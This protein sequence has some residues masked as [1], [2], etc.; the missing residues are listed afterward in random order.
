MVN[1]DDDELLVA[2]VVE[3]VDRL[4]VARLFAYRAFLR[5]NGT[6]PST[7]NTKKHFKISKVQCIKRV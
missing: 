1:D 4:V 5:S 6:R 7:I 2:W 3:K